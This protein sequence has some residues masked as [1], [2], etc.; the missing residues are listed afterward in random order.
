LSEPGA[1]MNVE[2]IRLKLVATT[3]ADVRALI[4]GMNENQ[5]AEL[6]PERR[7]PEDGR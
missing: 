3:P 1:L 5:R 6:S 7:V 4:D 2:T